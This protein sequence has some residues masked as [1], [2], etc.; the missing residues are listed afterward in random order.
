MTE[1]VETITR[2][3]F[4]RRGEGMSTKTL[5][6]LLGVSQMSAWRYC[7]PVDG[8]HQHPNNF[9]VRQRFESVTKGACNAANYCDP[10]DAETGEPVTIEPP[11]DEVRA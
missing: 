8:R 4:W 9:R 11:K 5:G 6:K 3:D 10:V 1:K 2:L 7:Q